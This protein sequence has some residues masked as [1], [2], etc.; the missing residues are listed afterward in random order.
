MY[1]I[2]DLNAVQLCNHVEAMCKNW[3]NRTLTLFGRI[4][5][6]KSLALAKFV[7][8]ILALPNPPGK[9]IKNLEKIF[10][11]FLWTSGLDRIKR[12]I[13][14]KDVTAGGLTMINTNM[15]IK[16]LHISWLERII[17]PSDIVSWSSMS[18]INFEKLFNFGSGGKLHWMKI[19]V[20][21]LLID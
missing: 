17:R 10:Y 19:K 16:S 6:I 9:L 15:F 5:I 2:W 7:H 21:P 12:R 1:D 3:S 11:K 4:T 20:S 13:I 18:N 14:I 8:L